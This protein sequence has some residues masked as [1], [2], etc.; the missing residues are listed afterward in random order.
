MILGPFATVLHFHLLL[1]P[2]NQVDILYRN[3]SIV[4]SNA[5]RKRILD[6]NMHD[7]DKDAYLAAKGESGKTEHIEKRDLGP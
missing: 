6:E 5:F 4:N 1:H 3:S 2:R 7:E